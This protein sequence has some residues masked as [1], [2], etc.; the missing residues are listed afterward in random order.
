MDIADHEDATSALNSFKATTIQ[1][2]H[3]VLLR[4]P[5]GETKG[6]KVE[7]DATISIGRVGSFRANELIGHPYGLTYEIRGKELTVQPPHT[8]Q[9][10]EET[11]ATNELINDGEFVQPLTLGEI[12]GLKKSGVHAS[13]IIKAQIEQHANYSLKTEY[14][15]E[16]YKQRKEAKYSKTFSTVEPTIY[17]VCDHWFKKDQNRIRDIR[18]DTLSQILNLA[19]VRPGGRYIVVDEA[20]G[21]LVSAILER[22]G[23]EGRLISICD[24]DSPPAYPVMTLMNF[25]KDVVTNIHSSL[26]WATAQEDYTPAVAQESSPEVGKSERHRIRLDKRKNA[27]DTLL[28]A[29]EELFAGEFDA[30]LI[31]SDYDPLEILQNLILYVAG[32]GSIVVQSPFSQPLTELQSKLRLDPGYLA[33]SITE[34]WL[35]RYQVL[36][37]RTHPTMSTSGSGGFLLHAI[38]V[39]DDPNAS[40]VSSHRQSKRQK[41]EAD[42]GNL[43]VPQTLESYQTTELEEKNAAVADQASLT[44]EMEPTG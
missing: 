25:R 9:E 10:V 33:P 17:N 24:V 36:P 21:L 23:G 32:S 44:N 30:L 20:S 28:N 42:E 35:R 27:A 43:T 16:K 31:A 4:L 39:Y 22:L 12:E 19:N 8:L 6:F 5:S 11:D 26:N 41:K 1:S 29:R 37:G 38:K 13:D 40:K 7:K 2:G 14:S 34:S 18:P 3:T 15:K